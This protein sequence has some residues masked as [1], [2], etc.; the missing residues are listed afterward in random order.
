[1]RDDYYNNSKYYYIEYLIL[2]KK[3]IFDMGNSPNI[4]ERMMNW[5]IRKQDTN[6][7]TPIRET[8]R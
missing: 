8:A 1:M 4:C 5:N 3:I 6:R 7:Q 2:I